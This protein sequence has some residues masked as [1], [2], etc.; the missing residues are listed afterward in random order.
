M[1]ATDPNRSSH[2][3][4]LVALTPGAISGP[5]IPRLLDSIERCLDAGLPGLL[6][7]ETALDD[8]LFW[9]LLEAVLAVRERTGTGLWLAVH[10]R[11][12][13]GLLGDCE[14]LHLGWRS[15]H[16]TVGRACIG[17]RRLLGFS[18]HRHDAPGA[19]EMCDY[20]FHSPVRKPGKTGFK[21][22]MEPV[23]WEGLRRF[24]EGTDRPTF[25]LGGLR[26][27]DGHRALRAGAQGVAVL[28]G[29]LGAEDPPG[30]VVPYLDDLEC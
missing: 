8:R 20:L 22:A 21:S 10:D 14:A 16:P 13:L 15:L 29:I 27:E 9:G 30:A 7:R 23:G 5:Q 24:V 28:S 25:A 6:L 4:R 26:P 1:A 19:F 12:H 18:S 11:I 2:L 17:E 3:P